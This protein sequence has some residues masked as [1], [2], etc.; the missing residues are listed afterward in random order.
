M[1]YHLECSWHRQRLL[2]GV[3][4]IIITIL[5]TST[6]SNTITTTSPPSFWLS[7]GS[8]EVITFLDWND[9]QFNWVFFSHSHLH[10]SDSQHNPTRYQHTTCQRHTIKQPWAK[11][12]SKEDSVMGPVGQ[13]GGQG[14]R[15]L[16]PCQTSSPASYNQAL[17][18]HWA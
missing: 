11:F 7:K 5:T 15:R 2:N 12:T 16:L 10:F 6:T 13:Y 8:P 14:P 1:R 18:L 17:L 9:L 3:Y 4:S